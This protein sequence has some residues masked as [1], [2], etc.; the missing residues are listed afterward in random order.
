MKTS[1][2]WAIGLGAGIPAVLI[3]IG[4]FVLLIK[5]IMKRFRKR[6]WHE[7]RTLP[8]ATHSGENNGKDH[9]K[10]KRL[11]SERQPLYVSS[12]NNAMESST[13]HLTIP[14]DENESLANDHLLDEK[15]SDHTIVQIQRERLNRIKEEENRLRPMIRL[16]HGEDEIQ[17][18]I[19][20]TQRE[21]DEAV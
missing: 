14:I 21:F 20:Q 3:L 2:K 15:H 12:T 19:D 5:F 8:K 17:K 9:R 16:S 6:A 18:I 7:I 10:I 13:P 4:L 11:S 1:A